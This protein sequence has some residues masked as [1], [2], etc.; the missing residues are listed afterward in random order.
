MNK[1][2]SL[3]TNLRLK[4]QPVNTLFQFTIVW[5][6]KLTRGTLLSC[7]C[8]PSFHWRNVL[9]LY[10]LLLYKRNRNSLSIVKRPY[11]LCGLNL[12][13]KARIC[14]HLF[15]V[16]AMKVKV[17]VKAVC[18]SYRT[19]AMRHIVLLPEW[20]PSFISRGAAHTKRRE[21]PLQ[22]EGRNYTWN[23]ASNP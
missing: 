20:V 23:L 16:P 2:K 5:Q 18:G 3:W 13:P 15:V 4:I 21:R 11:L 10:Q 17:K 8:H 1:L 19:D 6:M 22:V 7:R 9:N 14:F 12:R